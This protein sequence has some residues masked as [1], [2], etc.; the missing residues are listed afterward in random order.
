MTYKLNRREFLLTAT[1]MQWAPG[2]FKKL[3][4]RDI[5]CLVRQPENRFNKNAIE[6]FGVDRKVRYGYIKASETRNLTAVL[7]DYE[8]WVD[9][10]N[11]YEDGSTGFK[12]RLVGYAAS[13]VVI[14]F[15]SSVINQQDNQ[16][17]STKQYYSQR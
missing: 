3:K 17:I 16:S 9:E 13:N 4:L 12:I 1:G 7:D 5:I 6:I 11:L 15:Q 10:F 14:P 8:A 2:D